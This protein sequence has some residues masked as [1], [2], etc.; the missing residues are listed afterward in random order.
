MDLRRSLY[1]SGR[2]FLIIIDFFS[3]LETVACVFIYSVFYFIFGKQKK[4]GF[5]AVLVD[6]F[7]ENELFCGW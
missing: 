4:I 7:K 6:H 3:I 1:G 2:L 5:V